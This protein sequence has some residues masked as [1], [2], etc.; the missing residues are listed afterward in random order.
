LFFIPFIT[1]FAKG[2]LGLNIY[3]LG[4]SES[5]IL[6]GTA[7]T[8]IVALIIILLLDIFPNKKLRRS[9][10]LLKELRQIQEENKI[11]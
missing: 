5:A 3:E 4:L 6:T 10:H 2:I 7:G 11:I 8:F 9:I 1:V